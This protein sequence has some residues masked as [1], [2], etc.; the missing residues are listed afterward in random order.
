MAMGK[1]SKSLVSMLVMLAAAG[2]AASYAYWGVLKAENDEQARKEAET[3]AFDFESKAVKRVSLTAKGATTVIERDGDGWKLTAPIATRAD[4]FAIDPIVDRMTGLKHKAVVQDDAS[5]AAEF[6]LAS[7][8]IT[9]AATYTDAAGAE[10]TAELKIGGENTFD[11]SVYFAKGGDARIFSAEGG[12]QSTFDKALF[13]LRDK[14]IVTHEDKDVQTFSAETNGAA[15]AVERDG[16]GWKLTSP[17][18]DAADTAAVEGVLSK[19]RSL[20]A[21]VFAAETIGPA[22][23]ATYGFDRP[24]ALVTFGLGQDR[25]RKQ[26]QFGK[27]TVDGSEKTFARLVEGGPVV[28]IDASI[29]TDL[30]KSAADLRD[31]SVSPFDREKVLKLEIAPLDGEKLVVTHTKEKAPDASFATDKYEVAGLDGKLKSWKLSS[32]IY[33][34]S[35]LKGTSL[36][37]DAAKDLK[38]YGLDTPNVRFTAFGEGDQKLAEILIGAQAGTKYYAMKAGSNRVY[39]VEKGTIDELPRK[40]DDLVDAPPPPPSA[41]AAEAP[42]AGTTPQ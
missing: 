29:L 21:K 42:A 38:K 17:V 35:S 23:L 9:V 33:T 4:K 19:V 30:A 39:E 37:E 18:Q 26:L 11:M 31:R 3:K 41:P 5:R 40:K 7:P 2:G 36:V 20:R 8:S 34:L 22:E 25:A 12:L 13:D 24:A 32:A 28:E 6:G 15:W 10:K 27:A 16:S 14:A 1:K